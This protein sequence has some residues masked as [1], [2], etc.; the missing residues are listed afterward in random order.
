MLPPLRGKIIFF[1]AL[2]MLFSNWEENELPMT[3]ATII[4]HQQLQ[5]SFSSEFSSVLVHIGRLLVF[6]LRLVLCY[7]QAS[8]PLQQWYG[9]STVFY[10]LPK[11]AMNYSQASSHCPP[12]VITATF[13]QSMSSI[14]YRSKSLVTFKQRAYVSGRF[15]ELTWSQVA[16]VW[17]NIS[18]KGWQTLSLL[19]RFWQFTSYKIS[20]GALHAEDFCFR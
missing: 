9:Q 17:D 2:L 18:T 3:P 15:L 13:R 5:H 16:A 19:A 14:Y 6:V 10:N 8:C 20:P 12:L 4:A 7:G 11:M 1:H